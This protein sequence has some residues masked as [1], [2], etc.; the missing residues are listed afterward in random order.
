MAGKI[1]NNISRYSLRTYVDRWKENKI[2]EKIMLLNTDR[3]Q[4][5]NSVIGSYS[6]MTINV[7]KYLNLGPESTEHSLNN[8]N[9]T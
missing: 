7:N 5:M 9:I 2:V 3:R 8:N 1:K 6:I 4:G